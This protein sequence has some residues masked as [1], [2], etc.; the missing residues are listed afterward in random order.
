[1]KE[2]LVCIVRTAIGLITLLVNI[3]PAPRVRIRILRR[4]VTL[5]MIT[6]IATIM[7]GDRPLRLWTRPMFGLKENQFP[8]RQQTLLLDE[9]HATTHRPDPL[10]RLL[11]G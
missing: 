8:P 1:M 9:V 6:G 7:S 5:N 10:S 2:C 4:L 11:H 3:T